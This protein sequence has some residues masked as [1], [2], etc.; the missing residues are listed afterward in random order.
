MFSEDIGAQEAL[1]IIR[2]ACS[3]INHYL[4]KASRLFRG[5]KTELVFFFALSKSDRYP[6]WV[7]LTDCIELDTVNCNI[8]TNG[9]ER[10][11]KLV[12]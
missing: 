1:V 8:A 11:M 10:A 4:E 9:E 5:H 3:V 2:F 12:N 6:K 7:C